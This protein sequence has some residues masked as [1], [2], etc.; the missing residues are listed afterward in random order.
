MDSPRHTEGSTEGGK[1]FTCCL[2]VMVTSVL[3]L[4]LS[5][6]LS[7]NYTV[8]YL[9]ILHNFGFGKVVVK[10]VVFELKPDR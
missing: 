2:R 5:P 8:P 10:A 1:Y 3:P 9:R 4:A 6:L 7:Q